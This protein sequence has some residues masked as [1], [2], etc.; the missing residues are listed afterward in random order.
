M[1]NT[2]QKLITLK[3]HFNGFRGVLHNVIK[4]T[5]CHLL[6]HDEQDGNSIFRLSFSLSY[7]PVR[8]H[9]RQSLQLHGEGKN[10]DLKKN[11]S[12][13]TFRRPFSRSLRI[14]IKKST[15]STKLSDDLFCHSP[16]FSPVRPGPC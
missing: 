15:L 6:L 14:L 7:T 4:K 10:F 13:K 2:N 12:A 5:L 8:G 1:V 11:S 3:R 9:F 16:E